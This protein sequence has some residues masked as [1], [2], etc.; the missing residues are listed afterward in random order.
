MARKS[1]D[2]DNCIVESY[3]LFH[4]LRQA[5][6]AVHKTREVELKKYGL[7]PEQ[8]GAL[9][10]IRSLGNKATPAELSRWLFRERNTTTILLK[11][12]YKLGLIEKKADTKRKN[13]IRLS[14]T[15]KGEEAYRHSIEFK[16]FLPIIAV[17]PKKKR[18]QLWSLL[19]VVRL[20]VFED[21]NIDVRAYSNILDKPIAVESAGQDLCKD[22]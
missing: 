17:L 11:R 4:L 19:Q 6:D 12:M 21:L 2:T 7:T 3:R 18:K 9:V 13:V 16:S 8:S 1:P 5:S 22:K 15:A 14:L 20:K 10:C